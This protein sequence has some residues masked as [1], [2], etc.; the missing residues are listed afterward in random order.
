MEV[1][2]AMGEIGTSKEVTEK[3]DPGGRGPSPEPPEAA[4][5]WDPLTLEVWSPG[6]GEDGGLWF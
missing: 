6:L 2:G 3:T 1:L 5:P 4:R